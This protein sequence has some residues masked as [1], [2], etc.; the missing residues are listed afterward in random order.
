MSP[1]EPNVF[2][3]IVLFA[4][5]IT[6]AFVAVSI[7]QRGR[8]QIERVRLEGQV[9]LLREK[10]NT[11][12]IGSSIDAGFPAPRE[13]GPYG[14]Y[15]FVDVPDDYKSL[16]H[17]TLNGF[18]EFA[19]L[20]GYR[21]SIAIDTSPPGKVGFRFTIVDQGVTVSTSAVRSDLD[22]YIERFKE[23][24]SFER[25]PM[26]IDPVEHERLEA[27]LT[28]RFA[29]IKN[30]AD[31]YK[32]KAIFLEQLVQEMSKLRFGGVGYLP[33]PPTVIVNQVEQ[34]SPQV[35]GSKYH[36]EN[37]A[38]AAVGKGNSVVVEG[39]TISIGSTHSERQEQISGLNELIGL[40]ARSDLGS[41]DDA[42]RQLTN[43]REEL[44]DT[45]IPNPGLIA[46]YLAK[47]RDA[48]ALA[49][50]GTSICQK[51]NQVLGLFGVSM[52]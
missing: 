21:V 46:R 27:A 14:G 22:E 37:S 25:L 45:E 26:V 12:S 29:L 5:S 24:G 39:S 9:E 51:A 41:K 44:A 10:M 36:V 11:S 28:S 8:D 31:M 4:V 7:R 48:L 23:S 15:V 30:N 6:A 47:A 16:L 20:K 49:E 13:S 17:D 43:A 38:G 40:V 19:R 33:A 1:L 42:V 2:A 50:M 18:E 52:H 3:Y 32:A 35:T 34:G